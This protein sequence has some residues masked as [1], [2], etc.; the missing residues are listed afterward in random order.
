MLLSVALMSVEW[1]AN[2]SITSINRSNAFFVVKG[3][4]FSE[5]DDLD[6]V[7]L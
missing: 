4:I 6:R 3:G 2:G 5:F 7:H 1:V